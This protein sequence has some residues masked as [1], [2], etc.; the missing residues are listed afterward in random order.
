GGEPFDRGRLCVEVVA[1]ERG[2][3]GGRQCKRGTRQAARKGGTRD[4]RDGNSA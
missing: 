1:G 2:G 3:V 4:D